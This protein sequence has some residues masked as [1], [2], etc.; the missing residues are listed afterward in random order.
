MQN[1]NIKSIKVNGEFWNSLNS[2]ALGTAA[3]VCFLRASYW[4]LK[5]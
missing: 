1:K 5:K 3:I 4:S 2:A